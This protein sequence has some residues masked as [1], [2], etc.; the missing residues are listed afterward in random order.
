MISSHYRKHPTA[1]A[2]QLVLL[3]G[4]CKWATSRPTTR[5]MRAVRA[6]RALLIKAK[7]QI[8][9]WVKEPIPEWYTAM[10]DRAKKLTVELKAAQMEL[11]F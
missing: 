3:F 9:Q 6:Q 10:R 11:A 5:C 7:A 2:L 4:P 1:M 8:V